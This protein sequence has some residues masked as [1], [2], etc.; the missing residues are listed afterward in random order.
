MAVAMVSKAWHQVT[1]ISAL[2]DRKDAIERMANTWTNLPTSVRTVNAGELSG[3]DL[4]MPDAAPRPLTM[5]PP[6]EMQSPPQRRRFQNDGTPDGHGTL[7]PSVHGHLLRCR[8][9]LT[10]TP[11]LTITSLPI[12]VTDD[13]SARAMAAIQSTRP[14]DR[15]MI[16]GRFIVSPYGRS[17]CRAGKGLTQADGTHR[18]PARSNLTRAKLAGV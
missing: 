8:G 16:K 7:E 4:M 15:R 1:V 3:I 2:P 18:A 9:F 17:R 6:M 10:V 12:L 14:T 13:T 5:T 11:S